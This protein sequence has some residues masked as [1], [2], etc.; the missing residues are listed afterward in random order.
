M[1]AVYKYD[2]NTILFFGFLFMDF[3]VKAC[4]FHLYSSKYLFLLMELFLSQFVLS[5]KAEVKLIF[6]GFNLFFH[7]CKAHLCLC[8]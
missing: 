1:K 2:Y 8:Y 5:Y 3:N 4:F 6:L 7:K